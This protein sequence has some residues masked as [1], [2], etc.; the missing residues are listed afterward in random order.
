MSAVWCVR[1]S[2]HGG[3]W[4]SYA[5]FPLLK[6]L[7]RGFK[8]GKKGGRGQDSAATVGAAGKAAAAAADPRVMPTC[9]CLPHC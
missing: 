8:R 4:L 5:N 7:K 1:A 6:R 3:V 2:A 9:H